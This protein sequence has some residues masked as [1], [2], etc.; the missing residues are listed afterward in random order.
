MAASRQ[1]RSRVT[2]SVAALVLLAALAGPGIAS[3][4]SASLGS[5]MS[6]VP[7]TDGS[8]DAVPDHGAVG[9]AVGVFPF[10]NCPQPPGAIDW[11]VVVGFTQGASQLSSRD[12][13]IDAGGNWGGYFTIPIGAQPG[14]ASL[15]AVC[16]DSAHSSQTTFTYTP[17]PITV[18]ASTFAGPAAGPPGATVSIHDVGPC[19]VPAGAS[20][21]TAIVH[22]GQGANANIAGANMIVDGSGHWAGTLTIPY[23]LATGAASL[24]ASCFDAAHTSQVTLDYAALP[25]T[26]TV[27]TFTVTPASDAAGSRVTVSGDSPCP[28]PAGA[29][30]WTALVSFARGGNPQVAFRNFAV[31]PSGA[32][33]GTLTVPA[34]ASLGAAQLTASCFDPSHASQVA[35]DYA[36]DPFTVV[37]DTTRPAL[38]LPANRRAN[39]TKPTGAIVSFV[40]TATDT[41]DPT[42]VVA[43]KPASGTTFR[44]TT[45]TV[46]CTATDHAGNAAKGSFTVHVLGADAQLAALIALV[47]ADHLSTSLT[48]TLDGDL[49]AA[50]TALAAHRKTRACTDVATF[51]R[52][53]RSATS[54]GITSAKA[55]VLVSSGTRIRAVIGC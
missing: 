22:I 49:A 6:V 33:S 7:A 42:P 20:S 29:G 43:C 31:G 25:F 40:V 13:V 2:A 39:A 16:F 26:V 11:T 37:Q 53:V 52:A 34:S 41:Q 48:R 55:A 4:S 1:A 35:L 51:V 19:P 12:Y 17:L 45:T 32:W 10:A 15:T 38:H 28:Q 44:I 5:A 21:W 46:A 36:P 30:G 23:G 54:H 47:K 14:A 8:F 3:G 24:T 18:D 50:R 9:A 27:P